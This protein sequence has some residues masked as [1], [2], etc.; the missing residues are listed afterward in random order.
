MEEEGD[1]EEVLGSSGAAASGLDLEYD[2]DI[3]PSTPEPS[4]YETIYLANH[5]APVRAAAFNQEGTL[6]ATA[7]ADCSIKVMDVE[8]MVAREVRPN[9]GPDSDVHHPVPLPAS[10]LS[11]LPFDVAEGGR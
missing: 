5:K 11:V 1:K 7:S 10:R 6:V 8:R 2:A 4:L 9:S 3:A